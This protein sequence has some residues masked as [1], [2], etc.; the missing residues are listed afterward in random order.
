MSRDEDDKHD[1]ASLSHLTEKSIVHTLAS[2]YRNG[3]VYTFAG[4]S[5]LVSVSILY[6]RT[7]PLFE[8]L[9]FVPL[10][11]RRNHEDSASFLCRS[12]PVPYPRCAGRERHIGS[13]LC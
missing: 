3:Q 5:I 11:Q 2:R 1:L 9:P 13:E 8:A 7:G 4:S 10:P 6:N 12:V